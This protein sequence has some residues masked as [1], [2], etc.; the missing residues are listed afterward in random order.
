MSDFKFNCPHCN[1][2]LEAPED[3]LGTTIECPACNGSLQLPEPLVPPSP[4]PPASPP[5]PDTEADPDAATEK[6][7]AYIRALGGSPPKGL[8]KEK[9]SDIIDKLRSTA[10]PTAKQLELLKKLGGTV[11]KRMTSEQASDLIS[12]L[13]D[14]QPPTKQQIKFIKMLG[15]EVPATKGEA[16]EVCQKLPTT[17]PATAQQQKQAAELGIALPENATFA[18][19]NEL[20]SDGEMD[21]DPEEGKPPTKAQLNKI[22]KLGGDPQKATNRWRADEYIERLEEKQ[23]EF[24]SRV[25]DAI[26]WM[27]GDAESRGMMSVKKPSKAVMGKA[28][29]YGD[30]QGWGESWENGETESEYNPYNQ[31]DLAIYAVA[32]E[33]LKDGESVPVLQ[34]TPPRQPRGKGC[35]SVILMAAGGSLTFAWLVVWVIMK[36]G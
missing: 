21:A 22:A 18:Q 8:T 16:S 7:L 27:F 13:N 17:A 11:T 1:Q 30:A 10:P 12:Q 23:E 33:L 3:M 5:Q 32:P 14:N 9:A 35:L 19:A 31:M 24:E 28:L 2:S 26:E 4:R 29:R 36:I 6:Q 25:E 20:L 34:R 15:G